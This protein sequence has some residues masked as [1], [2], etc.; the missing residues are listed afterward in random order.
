MKKVHI[1]VLKS[2]IGPFILTFFIALFILLLQFIFTYIDD[3]VGKGLSWGIIAELLAYASAG[4]VPMALPLA[5]LL[6]SIMTF[7]NLGEKYELVAL[8]SSGISL[9]KVMRPLIIFILAI[10][11]SAF[12]FSNYVIPYTNLKFWALMGDIKTQRPELNIKEG[13]FYDEIDDYSIKIGKKN[14]KTGILRDVMIYNHTKRKGNVYLMIADSGTMHMTKDNKYLILTMYNGYNYEEMDED[15]IRVDLRTIPFR[16]DKFKR[17]T[18][19]LALTSFEFERTDEKVYQDHHRMLNVAQLYSKIDSLYISYDKRV[20]NFALNLKRS[21][22]FKKEKKNQLF[23]KKVVTFINYEYSLDRMLR[24]YRYSDKKDPEIKMSQPIPNTFRKPVVSDQYVSTGVKNYDTQKTVTQAVTFDYDSLFN[25]FPPDEKSKFIEQASETCRSIK[26]HAEG[27]KA[28]HEGRLTW[29]KKHEIELHRKFTVSLACLLL[30]F[31]GAPLGAI[32]RKGGFGMPV[33]VSVLFFILYYIL[34]IVGEKFVKEFVTTAYFGMWMPSMILLPIGMFLTYKATTDSTLFN[35]ES[36]AA[37]FSKIFGSRKTSNSILD[38]VSV[39]KFEF[40]NITGDEVKSKLKEFIP[41]L[42]NFTS[43]EIGSVSLFKSL[44]LIKN[45]TYLSY[46]ELN[47][48]YK[49]LLKLLITHAGDD[50]NLKRNIKN[51]VP[52]PEITIHSTRLLFIINLLALILFP[53][54]IFIFYTRYK[55]RKRLK[56]LLIRTGNILQKTLTDIERENNS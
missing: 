10:S 14:T 36:Y 8:K 17:E 21:H 28:D 27:V 2:Y 13:V 47:K 53:F 3:L 39:N 51:L 50:Y 54:G 23:I 52:F 42:K 15:Q 20:A 4:L 6:S 12:F 1:F 32:I 29:I 44:F 19:L 49:A 16:R 40:I 43:T 46:S 38:A 31:I 30:F 26:R 35:T 11:I 48:Q 37:F 45:S 34:T 24:I 55:K 25:S 5:I 7:G 9:Q 22:Y 56:D 18:I 41:S 33:V